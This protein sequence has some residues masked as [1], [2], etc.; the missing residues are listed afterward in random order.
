MY[1]MIRK[2][3]IGKVKSVSGLLYFTT[4]TVEIKDDNKIQISALKEKYLIF[5]NK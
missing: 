4:T 1:P 3:C 2:Y 5:L